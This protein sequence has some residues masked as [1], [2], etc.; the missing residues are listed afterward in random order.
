MDQSIFSRSATILKQFTSASS[1]QMQ[2]IYEPGLAT[3]W[4]KLPVLRYYGFVTDLRA[5]IDIRSLYEQTLPDLDITQSRTERLTAV[6]DMEWGGPRYELGLYLEASN[7]PLCKVAALSLLNREP[8]YHVNLVPYFSDNALINIASDARILARVEDVGYGLL[9]GLDEVVI[10]GSVK[11]EVSTL[12]E[13]AR[14]ISYC[15]SFGQT[16]GTTS[17]QLLPL[18][19]NRLQATFVNT[20]A[21]NKIFL[22]YGTTAEI[23]KGITLMPNGGS[24]EINAENPYQGVI[25]AIASA[26]STPMT[27]M[28]CV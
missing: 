14:V 4:D 2:V 16:L 6:R 25:S 15:Q 23:N 12:P 21:S 22:H 24:Y 11:E 18:N 5:K 19:A 17:L 20:H 7:S 9:A 28:E 10:F 13:D 26:A 3:P 8:Y 27:Y 1:N